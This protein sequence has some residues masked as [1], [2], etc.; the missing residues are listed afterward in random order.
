[1]MEKYQDSPQP[2]TR[3]DC[4]SRGLPIMPQGSPNLTDRAVSSDGVSVP[5]GYR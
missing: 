1:M 5:V 4:N 3:D 2:L